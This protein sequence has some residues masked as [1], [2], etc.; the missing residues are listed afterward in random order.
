MNLY[1]RKPPTVKNNIYIKR[2]NS[3]II[4]PEFQNKKHT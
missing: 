4:L 1:G 2:L 3:E